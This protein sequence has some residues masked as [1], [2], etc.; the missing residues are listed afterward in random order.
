MHIKLD[1]FKNFVTA[2][3]Q[4][5]YGFR[6]LQQKLSAKS[7]AKL[8]AGRPIFIRLEIRKLIIDKNHNPLEKEAWNQFC[9]VVKN[10]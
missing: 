6:Y 4:D 3:D 9:F 1:L 10:C 2:I 5:G 7:E 8:K